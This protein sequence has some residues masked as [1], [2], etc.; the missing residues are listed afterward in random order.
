KEQRSI[1]AEM[2]KAEVVQSKSSTGSKVQLGNTKTQPALVAQN[3]NKKP[4][5]KTKSVV[6]KFSG[7][8]IQNQALQEL[9][10]EYYDNF[11]EELP[12]SAFGQ[13]ETHNRLGW[14]HSG[15]IDL[16]IRPDSIQGQNVL[17]F[18]RERNIAFLA[19]KTSEPG[20]STGAHIHIGPPSTRLQ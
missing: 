19:F 15:R 11:K 8:M 5:Y 13:S 12:I 1:K 9:K 17:K 16:A 3:K 14:D 2:S 6:Y 10:K 18:L 7:S 20:Y 4:A